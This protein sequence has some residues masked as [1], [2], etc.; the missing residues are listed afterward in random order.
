MRAQNCFI[1][2]CKA[3]VK[4]ILKN[5]FYGDLLASELTKKM[6][7]LSSQA[8]CLENNAKQEPCSQHKGC[9][10]TALK[11]DCVS[12]KSLT[13]TELPASKTKS[14]WLYIAVG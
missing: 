7:K 12:F 8:N 11:A 13:I 2:Q 10:C 9:V 4:K 14:N 6:T 3:Y 5:Q 1:K